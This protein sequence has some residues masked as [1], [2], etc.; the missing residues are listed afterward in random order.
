MIFLIRNIIHII[1]ICNIITLIFN[2]FKP[3]TPID[4]AD[5][6]LQLP[7]P[8]KQFLISPPASPP[9]G[10]V[11]RAEGEPLINYDLLAAIASLKPGK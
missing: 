8:V 9:E 11:P 6:H 2:I 5:Q 7:A 10:W 1:S 3:V 4:A